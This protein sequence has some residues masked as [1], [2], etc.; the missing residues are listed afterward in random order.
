MKIKLNEINDERNYRKLKNQNKFD[1]IHLKNKQTNLF[2]IILFSII[3]ILLILFLVFKS[4]KNESENKKNI[5][6]EPGYKLNDGNF[7]L[8]YTFKAIFR[9]YIE[10]EKINII[11]CHPKNIIKMVINE[12][13][14]QPWI[15][16]IFPTPGEHIIF[17]KL[18]LTNKNSFSGLFFKI[19]NMIYFSFSSIFKSNSI[20]I[21]ITNISYMFFDCSSLNFIDFNNF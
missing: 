13:E 17:L 15:D 12:T 20:N 5:K 6:C 2:I 16:F 18:N 1:E 19:Q 21:N 4:Y 7:S 10:N 9:T 14:V 11:N 8:N 3:F